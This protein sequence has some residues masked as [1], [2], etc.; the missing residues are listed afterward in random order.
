MRIPN[1]IGY[2]IFCIILCLSFSQSA[3]A[4]PIAK[5]EF[6]GNNRLSTSLLLDAVASGNDNPLAR[7]I[8]TASELLLAV[9]RIEDKARAS[10]IHEGFLQAAIDSFQSRLV[11][12][13]DSSKGFQLTLFITE[14]APYHVRSVAI[15]GSSLLPEQEL[16]SAM[17]TAPSGI[18]DEAVLKSDISTLLLRYDHLGYPLASI[19][20][21]SIT[22]SIDS[23]KQ[24]GHLDIRL[25]VDEGKR[26]RI[27]KILITG[28]TSTSSDVITR[29]LRLPIGSYYD[30]DAL[31]AAKARADRLGFF[32]SIAQPEVI[33]QNDSIV[34][35]VF[36]VKEAST[37]TIDGILG[38][39]PPRN[40]LEPGYLSG[41]VDLGFRN[42]SG[43]G[44]NASLH[45]DRTT[46]SSQTLEVHYLEPWL[47]GYPLNAA[48]GFIQRQQDST[49]TR[50]MG[51]GDLSL[52]V[53][54][55][56]KLIG[57][58]SIDRVVPNNQLE[59]AFSVYDSRTVSTGLSARVDT[60]DD[61]LA[62]RIGVL[63][64]FGASYGVKDIYGPAGFL[65]STTP[66]SITLRTL[67]LDFS[68]YHTLFS[69]VLVGAI[70][71]HARSVSANAGQLDQSD[72]C[73]IGGN[74][75]IRGYREEEL[76]ASRYAYSNLEV[77]L[78]AGHHSFFFA[79]TDVGY[80]FRD[81]T[82]SNPVEQVLYPLSYGIGA[83]VESTLGVLS[84]SIGLARGE[85][86]DQAKFHFG[87]I[88]EF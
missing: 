86:V 51:T 69:P 73:R 88:K 35:I 87:L 78:M 54:E 28:N 3:N 38:Y 30:E 79:F 39:N 75:S 14:G 18:L 48:L 23:A 57:N 29:E 52:I 80:T 11:N 26:A 32:E 44:R 58:L 64:I 67:S 22:P 40:N 45:Y 9:Q 49:F 1:S 15:T 17:E 81:S 56:L 72:L 31:T 5:L 82:K 46:P 37:S 65:D 62:P 71:L 16:L 20:I 34:A 66:A 6:Q 63:G 53:T 4:Y 59:M 25:H 41:L 33:L 2:L 68:G 8:G 24:E 47:F 12:P 84:V 61:A 76:L 70:G 77:R 42:I 43:T 55:D 19:A 60:R 21:K 50:T 85:P 7:N 10:Y 36:T 27:G 74:F 83:Q 13:V